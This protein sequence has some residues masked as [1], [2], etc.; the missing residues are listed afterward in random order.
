[1]TPLPRYERELEERGGPKFAR[2][3]LIAFGVAAAVGLGIGLVWV[4]AGLISQSAP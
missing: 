2:A 3:V 4:V 1:M